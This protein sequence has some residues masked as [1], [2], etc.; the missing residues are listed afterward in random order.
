[1]PVDETSVWFFVEL[2]LDNSSHPVCQ[3]DQ[4]NAFTDFDQGQDYR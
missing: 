2:F 4:N 1:M 3:T